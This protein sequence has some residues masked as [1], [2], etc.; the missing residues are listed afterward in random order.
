VTFVQPVASPSSLL[1]FGST[2]QLETSDRSSGHRH[3]HVWLWS[4]SFNPNMSK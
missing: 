3:A 2:T 4:P 1:S